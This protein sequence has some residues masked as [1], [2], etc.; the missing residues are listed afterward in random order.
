MPCYHP[1]TGYKA[2]S[3]EPGQGRPVVFNRRAGYSD[4][5][6]KLP[7]GQCIGCRLDRSRAWAIRCVHEAQL[8]HENSF[9]TLTYN[10]RNC[11]ADYSVDR[12]DF[13]LFIKRL[14]K[15]NPG[16]TIR[17]YHCGEYGKEC[18]VCRKNQNSCTCQVFSETLGR[19]HYHALI[20]GHDFEDKK[21]WKQN[22]NGDN[23]YIS[24]KLSKLWPLGFS[25]LGAITYQSAVYTARYIIKKISGDPALDHYLWSNPETG[26]TFDRQ[27]EYTTMSNRP[28]IGHDWLQKYRT[29]VFPGDFVVINGRRHPTPR[30]YSELL[31]QEQPKQFRRIRGQRVQRG[32]QHPEDQTTDR[33]K[34]RETVKQLQLSRL[35]REL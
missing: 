17:Y 10:L 7:C 1:L 29:D 22:K 13:Q 14:R 11:P 34:T 12:R 2:L 28:G 23:L 15:S 3:N 32:K 6:I 35:K 30:Y 24:K 25:S 26:E 31:K 9:L 8:H 5:P 21:L 4:L 27:P 19:P 20:F 33:L 18:S 16:K